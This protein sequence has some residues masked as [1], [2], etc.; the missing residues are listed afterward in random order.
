MNVNQVIVAANER[1]L[2]RIEEGLQLVLRYH[3]YALQ[4]PRTIPSFGSTNVTDF[5]LRASNTLA[6]LRAV[7]GAGSYS[8]DRRPLSI[9]Y[10]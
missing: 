1:K 3:G 4:W 6:L 2:L 7:G 5:H 8:R 10:C 9:S